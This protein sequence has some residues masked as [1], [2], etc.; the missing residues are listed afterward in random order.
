MSARSVNASVKNESRVNLQLLTS[1]ISLPHGEWVSYPEAR[2]SPND[3]TSW[4]T[5]SDGFMTGTEGSFTYQFIYDGP[6]GPSIET[7]K[8]Y[9]DNP[10]AGGNGY[11]ITCSVPKPAFDVSYSG[12]SGNNATVV[13][14][15]KGNS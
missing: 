9:W 7:V 3:T 4:Q 2:L 15:F 8:F 5:D 10:Y 14:H 1:S 13:Y 6:D 11:S 12:G